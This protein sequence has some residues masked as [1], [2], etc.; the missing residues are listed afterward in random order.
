MPK[1]HQ[2]EC[3]MNSRL[4]WLNYV[5]C[6]LVIASVDAARLSY[7]AD[8]PVFGRCASRNAV[9]PDGTPPTDWDV[10]S[11]RNIK[12]TAQLGSSTFAAPVV[13]GGHVYIGTNNGAGYLERYPSKVDLGCLLC[14]QESDGAFL[15]QYSAEKLPIGFVQDWPLQGLV[16]SALVEGDRL[17]FVSNRHIVVCLDAEGFRDGE[18]DGP[19]T[20]ETV[21]DELE[22]DVIW[23]YD[24]IH[25]LGVFPHPPGM[26]PNTRC[27]IAA[28]YKD[29]IYVVTGNG[30]DNTWVN[31]PAPDAPSLVCF[32]KNSGKVL[33]SDTSP[34]KNILDCQA[35]HPLVAEINGRAQVIVPQ[36][37]GWIR[38][39]DALTGDLI[40]KFDI[41]P[42]ESKW[43]LGAGGARNNILAT[44][45]L[46]EGRVY[47]ASGQQ[48]EHG[49]G[50]GRL[51]CLDPTLR[52]DISAELAV[53]GNG[54][55]LVHRRTQAVDPAQ[56]E[57]A[58]PN[59]R[60]GLVWEFV[61]AD[62]DD[63]FLNTMHRTMS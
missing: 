58:V 47:V 13:A 33:W 23:Q 17:W 61:K 38:S 19:F 60:S 50:V 39:F 55:A 4:R 11:G 3:L 15:W 14:F 34:G 41:N 52:G 53:D 2:P 16:S 1:F 12:W 27:S 40:W 7:A 57:K 32:D 46:Y 25:E 56:G 36:G 54:Q 31:I 42:K 62:G 48:A 45:V 20:D 10:T 18:N 44:P 28:S 6:L 63:D 22:A 35:A 29:R 49:D 51:V 24:L 30:T 8:W 37:D 5:A 43:V 59:P 26:G 21:K 9:I